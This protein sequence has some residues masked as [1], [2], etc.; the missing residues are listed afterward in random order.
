MALSPLGKRLNFYRGFMMELKERHKGL[1][2][3]VGG[4]TNVGLLLSY[5]RKLVTA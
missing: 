5:G 1:V 4:K 2:A 3:V